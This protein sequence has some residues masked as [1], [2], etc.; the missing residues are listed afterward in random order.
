MKVPK[1]TK[2]MFI[3]K[4]GTVQK[5]DAYQV[6]HMG[7]FYNTVPVDPKTK[8][9]LGEWFDEHKNVRDG[10]LIDQVRLVKFDWEYFLMNK[11][12]F[13]KD[14]DFNKIWKLNAKYVVTTYKKKHICF[15]EYA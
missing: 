15:K 2:A 3:K 13:E 9:K 10:R 1:M 11:K 4:V 5:L 7:P 6:D 14:F 12:R 8:A